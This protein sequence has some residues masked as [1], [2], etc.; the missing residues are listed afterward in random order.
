MPDTKMQSGGNEAI[1]GR[2]G[3]IKVEILRGELVESIHNIACVIADPQGA[4]HASWG[5]P[6][7]RTYL[8]SSAKP[9]QAMPA[10]ISGAVDAAN[11]TTA[12]LAL[13]CAS[14][15]GTD[16]HV[17]TAASMLAR[18]GASVEDL[19]CGTHPPFDEET[20]L[21]LIRDGEDPGE[22]R[23]NCSGKH[24]GMLAQADYLQAP[25]AGYLHQEHPVQRQILTILSTMV[26]LPSGEIEVGIDGCSAPNFA[27]PL[28]NAA[29]GYAHLMDPRALAPDL[30]AA[31]QRVVGAMTQHPDLVSGDGRFDTEL[32]RI[33]KG[34]LLSKGGAEGFQC[35]GIPSGS[36][37]CDQPALGMA[38]KVLDGD[39]GHRALTIAALYVLHAIGAIDDAERKGMTRFD[40]RPIRNL[41]GLAIGEVRI[42][43]FFPSPIQGNEQPQS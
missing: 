29:L 40:Q 30:A 7:L 12:E 27:M 33:T 10:V 25:R 39:L 41:R 24:I 21:R 37:G 14:H 18:I 2:Y 20:N 5:D 28:R 3:T 6:E 36:T 26:V 22:L 9:F 4:L 35:I 31:S 19:Q 17:A 11:F 23:N 32:M 8:R 43:P 16:R 34:R 42:S 38:L 13:M 1:Q 15:A